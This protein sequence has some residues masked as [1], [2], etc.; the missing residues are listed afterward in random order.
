MFLCF[1]DG[2][3]TRNCA[4]GFMFEGKTEHLVMIGVAFLGGEARKCDRGGILEGRTRNC[5]RSYIF[6]W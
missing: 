3:R 1:D 2:G 5:D 4:R 6:R